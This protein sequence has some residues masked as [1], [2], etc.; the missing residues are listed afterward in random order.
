M[1]AQARPFIVALLSDFGTD[2]PYV[3]CM[4]AAI[5]GVNPSVPI[6][7]IT[8]SVQAHSIVAA[9]YTLAAT[10]RSFPEKTVFVCVVDPGVGSEC[11]VLI[12]SAGRRYFVAPDNGLLSPVFED[13][14]LGR[15]FR[16]TASHFFSAS[17]AQTFHGRDMMAPLAGWISKGVDI[18]NMGEPYALYK[19]VELPMPKLVAGGIL[20]GQIWHIDRFGNCITNIT[21]EAFDQA[22]G[23]DKKFVKAV[24][25][26]H[27]IKTLC[28]YYAQAPVRGGPVCLFGSLG[29]VELACNR[30]SASEFLTANVGSIVG[31]VFD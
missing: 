15:V 23:T 13:P 18:E 11:P 30:A 14:D 8:H 6:I 21:R 2:D 12:A 1:A 25:G 16:A 7:D 20:E 31:I 3:G 26:K 22:A 27:E 28:N 4:K 19:R 9:A 24:A 5:L 10:Y 17:V 29:Y